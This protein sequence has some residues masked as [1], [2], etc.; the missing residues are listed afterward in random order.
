MGKTHILRRS[1]PEAWTP[2]RTMAACNLHVEE[3]MIVR[4]GD[5]RNATCTHCLTLLAKDA[6]RRLCEHSFSNTQQIVA[7][8]GRLRTV[9]KCARCRL[10]VLSPIVDPHTGEATNGPPGVQDHWE[11]WHGDA[12]RYI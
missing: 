4:A 9:F 7:A 12:K 1:R 6:G 5:A 10:Q 11:V 2:G 3:R 8:R